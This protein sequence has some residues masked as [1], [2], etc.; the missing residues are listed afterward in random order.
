LLARDR[1][2]GVPE[3]GAARRFTHDWERE[4]STRL[5][6]GDAS[7]LGA[8]QAKGRLAAGDHLAMVD[9]AYTAWADDERAGRRSLLIAGDRDTVRSLNE[10]ARAERVAAGSVEPAGIA[11]HDGLLAGVGDRVVTRQN[12]RHFTVGDGW[13]KN[14][15]TWTVIDRHDDA[16]LTIRR[17]GGGPAVVLPAAY[18]AEDV[19][20]GYATTA[21]RAQ[22]AT[23][24]TAHAVISGPSMTREVLYV[25]MTRARESNRA[26]VCTDAL[27]EPL[28][29]FVDV[30]TTGRDVL[31]AVLSHVGAA[32]SAHEVRIEETEAAASIRTL[33]AEYETLAHLAE[34]SH[35]TAVLERSGISTEQGRAIAESPAFGALTTALRRAEGSG[36][37]IA[38]ALP[39][40]ADRADV[41]AVDLASVLHGRIGRWTDANLDAGRGRRVRLVA[42]LIPAASRTITGEMGDALAA[43]ERLIDER[44]QELVGRA[45]IA[46]APWLRDLGTVPADADGQRQCEARART[47]TAYRDRYGVT[48]PTMALGELIVSDRQ[49]AG[50]LA[51]AAE[52]L[53]PGSS[54]VTVYMQDRSPLIAAPEPILERQTSVRR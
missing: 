42:G 22:G 48:D 8:Y 36:L 21:F 11:L 26:Y 49:R 1:G 33:A 35:W 12:D 39:R 38:A 34:A 29:G 5:R 32:T 23:V 52:V 25:A 54:I 41:G 30:P 28:Q 24:D 40:L 43:R 31:T 16:A 18:V 14:G 20:L 53:R 46:G 19:E 13:V 45:V 37:D 27:P 17:E 47:V 15:D 6:L 10:R 7:C 51:L 4:A 9:A 50:A 44:A 2:P 3:L